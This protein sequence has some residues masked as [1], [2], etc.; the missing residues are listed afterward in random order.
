[1][2]ITSDCQRALNMMRLAACSRLQNLPAPTPDSSEEEVP[3]PSDV[4]DQRSLFRLSQDVG[5]PERGDHL[6]PGVSGDPLTLA[7][8][9]DTI[10]ERDLGLLIIE[11]IALIR[12][13]CS[14]PARPRDSRPR[15][16]LKMDR[17]PYWPT[18]FDTG[19]CRSDA[20]LETSRSSRIC[21]R[22]ET[23]PMLRSPVPKQ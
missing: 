15:G 13:C 20:R 6:T 21:P 22:E 7:G 4:P 3:L 12:D 14:I 18:N 2:L 8:R 5:S 16:R 10:G 1:M 23:S 19:S 9:P 11:R 17:T